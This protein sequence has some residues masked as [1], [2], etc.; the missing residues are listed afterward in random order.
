MTFILCTWRKK[1]PPDAV[2]VVEPANKQRQ[3]L[4]GIHASRSEEE[5]GKIGK[6]S[7][8]ETEVLLSSPSLIG[9]EGRFGRLLRRDGAGKRE[10]ERER[11]E[12]CVLTKTLPENKV[13]L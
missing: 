7:G 4:F 2:C 5:Q 8:T 6:K 11:F 1:S 13:A 9:P 10:A 3:H 12:S